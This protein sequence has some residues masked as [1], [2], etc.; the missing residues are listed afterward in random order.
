MKMDRAHAYQVCA[1]LGALTC[2]LPLFYVRYRFVGSSAEPARITVNFPDGQKRTLEGSPPAFTTQYDGPAMWWSVPL[3]YLLVAFNGAA[4]AAVLFSKRRC[5]G[6]GDS[7]LAWLA[8]IRTDVWLWAGT[9]TACIVF[10]NQMLFVRKTAMQR[11]WERELGIYAPQ[12]APIFIPLGILIVLAANVLAM[13]F[14]ARPCCASSG[15]APKMDSSS[16]A[17]PRGAG[18]VDATPSTLGTA[19][20]QNG[21]SPM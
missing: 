14:G 12:V 7:I 3:G 15:D 6:K 5:A 13:R 21:A 2:W 4:M 1:I 11:G 20:P 16:A 9:G 8:R 10:I 19:P 18:S 17:E